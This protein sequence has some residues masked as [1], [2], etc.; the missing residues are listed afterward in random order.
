MVENLEFD[1]VV[2]LSEQDYPIVPLEQLEQR[3]AESGVDAFIESEPIHL[4]EETKARKDRDLRYNYNYVQLPRFGLM[5]R[6]PPAIRRPIALAANKLNGA[7]LKVQRRVTVYVFPDGL[8]LRVG[9]RSKRSPFSETFLC[10]YGP[11]QMAL[12]R[13]AA[14]TVTEYVASHKEYVRYYA[15]TVIPDESATATI[16]CNDPTLK[17]WNGTLHWTRWTVG[18]HSH[19]DVLALNDLDEFVNFRQ[20]LREKVRFRRG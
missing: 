18:D 7:F 20:V 16:V 13:R 17:V 8:P 19:P 5:A 15:R 4:I 2:F 3:L 12:S 9:L 14:E 11:M 10:W 1:W 6:L